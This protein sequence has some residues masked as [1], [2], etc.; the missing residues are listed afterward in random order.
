MGRL[1]GVHLMKIKKMSAWEPDGSGKKCFTHPYIYLSQS[2]KSFQDAPISN[3]GFPR[4]LSGKESA[5]QC[6]RH[7]R[8]EFDPGVRNIPWRRKWQSTPVSL[9]GKSHGERNL[10]GYSPWSCK[11]SYMTE[12]QSVQHVFLTA[13]SDLLNQRV[14]LSLNTHISRASWQLFVLR[15]RVKSAGYSVVWGHL[16]PSFA[17]SAPHQ[18]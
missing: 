18:A 15:E 16:S 5:C 11:E 8:H 4:W 1:L 13:L 10:A 7:K 9:S 17:G 6:R 14:R 2:I 12:Q 3:Q